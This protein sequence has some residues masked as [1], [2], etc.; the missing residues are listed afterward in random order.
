M[1][2]VAAQG[3]GE[4]DPGPARVS[5]PMARLPKAAMTLGAGTGA[6]LGGCPR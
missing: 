1:A 4:V 5:T 2:G 3:G 6:D